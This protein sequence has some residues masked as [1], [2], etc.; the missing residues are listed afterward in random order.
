MKTITILLA[1]A[2]LL[3]GCTHATPTTPDPDP[4]PAFKVIQ[5]WAD[6]MPPDWQPNGSYMSAD[7]LATYFAVHYTEAVWV[8]YPAPGYCELYDYYH[9]IFSSIT[10]DNISVAMWL[11]RFY[12]SELHCDIPYFSDVE[13]PPC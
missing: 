11:Y 1:A 3:I 13:E 5:F 4:T 7:E 10:P 6:P 2:L 9:N 8:K 12:E